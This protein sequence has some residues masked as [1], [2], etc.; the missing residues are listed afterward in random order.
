MKSY[1]FCDNQGFDLTPHGRGV[2][3]KIASAPSAKFHALQG[4]FD[5]EWSLESAVTLTALKRGWRGK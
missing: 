2:G 5:A 4:A 3:N 1:S